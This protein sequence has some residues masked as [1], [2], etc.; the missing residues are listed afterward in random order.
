[1]ATIKIPFTSDIDH[2]V[3]YGREQSKN[4]EG[5]FEGDRRKGKF[6][7]KAPA[8]SFAGDYQ[9]N[10]KIIVINFTKKPLYLPA[11]VIE[12]FLKQHIK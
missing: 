11:F 1:M 6:D 4:F 3:A 9:V 7:F 10:D 8:G 12:Q 2:I 5:Q